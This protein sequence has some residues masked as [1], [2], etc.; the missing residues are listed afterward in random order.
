MVPTRRNVA[1]ARRSWLASP[2][3]KPAA[4]MAMRMACSWN[5]G[6]PSVLPSTRSSS[7]ARPCS[8]EGEGK[9]DRLLALAAAQI[10]VDHVALDRAGAHDRHLDDEIVE[11]GGFQPRQHVHL[12]P[13]L[14]LEDAERVA[15]W[16][17][18]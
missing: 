12:R 6:T 7:S 2:G 14:D 8:G 10:G 5:S 4:T 13:A 15:R 16:I 11:A 1:M 18:A 17:M 9:I 3:V